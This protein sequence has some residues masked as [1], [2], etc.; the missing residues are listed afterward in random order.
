MREKMLSNK[1][2]IIEN[3]KSIKDRV[4]YKTTKKRIQLRRKKESGFDWGKEL[5]KHIKK[6]ESDLKFIALN[7]TE[8]KKIKSDDLRIKFRN[9]L[10]DEVLLRAGKVKQAKEIIDNYSE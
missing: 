1:S 6:M 5:K 8:I 7:L 9:F 4:K 2:K 3:A 10:V